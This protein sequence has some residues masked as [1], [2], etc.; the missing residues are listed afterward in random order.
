MK[1]MTD[2]SPIVKRCAGLDIHRRIIVATI[3]CEDPDGTVKE[4]TREFGTFRKHRQELTQWLQSKRIELTVMESTGVYHKSIYKDLEKAGLPVQLVNARYVKQVP[5]RKTDV[6]DSQWLAS[7]ARFG[8]LKGSFVPPVDLREIRLITRYRSKQQGILASE[9]NR[10]HKILDD[11]GIRLGTVVSDING[12]S[13]RQIIAGLIE[14]K[15]LKELV[16]LAKG[17]LKAKSHELRE[18]LE[19][20]LS[21]QHRFLLK[22]IQAHIDYLEKEIAQLDQHLADAMKPYEDQIEL[23]QTIPGIQQTNAT[24]LIAEIGVDMSQFGSAEKLASWAGMC[25]GNNE[26]AGKKKAVRDER[27]IPPFKEPCVRLP[28]PP[29]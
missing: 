2:L 27:E 9:K 5:G 24:T 16:Q 21:V 28:M 4:E 7:L 23:L 10:L 14:G 11:S 3:L 29:E 26:S 22:Q 1:P 18:S 6:K 25:P 17:K 13:A 19:G 20:E 8:L 12:V 15:P